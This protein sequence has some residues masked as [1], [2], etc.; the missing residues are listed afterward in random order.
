[1]GF[2][3]ESHADSILNHAQRH[4]DWV[5]NK[6]RQNPSYADEVRGGWMKAG[7]PE[8]AQ[9]K[10]DAEAYGYGYFDITDYPDFEKYVTDVA[11]YLLT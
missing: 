2:S 11:D 3:R 8:S 6:I 4:R 1:L 9:L 5:S 10:I 7:I